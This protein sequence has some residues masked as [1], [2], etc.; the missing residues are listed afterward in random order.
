MGAEGLFGVKLFFQDGVL[1]V[2]K[3]GVSAVRLQAGSGHTLTRLPRKDRLE[4]SIRTA[5]GAWL[6]V[7][8]TAQTPPAEALLTG[9]RDW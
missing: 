2:F 5:R 6:V 8:T 4:L 1:E 3:R 9:A 7:F